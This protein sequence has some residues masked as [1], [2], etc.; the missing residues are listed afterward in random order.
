MA[1]ELPVEPLHPHLHGRLAHL[2]AQLRDREDPPANAPCPLA[3]PHDAIGRRGAQQPQCPGQ[4][5]HPIRQERAIR[6]IVNG[7]LDHG[8]VHAQPPPPHDPPLPGDRNQALKELRE[9]RP[10]NELGQPDQGLGVGDPLARDAAERAVDEVGPDLALAL[11][12]A[13]VE[14]VLEHEHAQRHRGRRSWAAPPRTERPTPREGL[15]HHVEQALVLQF[16][17]DAPEHRVP[18]L[19]AVGQQHLDKA[20]LGV[21]NPN[22]GVSGR[23]EGDEFGCLLATSTYIGHTIA[24][25]AGRRQRKMRHSAQFRPRRPATGAAPP[26]QFRT[27]K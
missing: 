27:A 24:R 17:V 19:L 8:R 3:Q 4:H 18:E 1:H 21:R 7:G 12:K 15:H 5:A 10:V 23:S 9:R 13:P 11:V 6:R 2:P 25:S 14:E 20:P 22:H 16:G 26:G